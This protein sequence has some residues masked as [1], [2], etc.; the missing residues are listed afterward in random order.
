MDAFLIG[1]ILV[2]IIFIF[3]AYKVFL[4]DF[5]KDTLND[6]QNSNEEEKELS[7]HKSIEGYGQ[8]KTENEKIYIGLGRKGYFQLEE[9]YNL[10][11]ADILF[12]PIHNR[13][14][15]YDFNFIERVH[16]HLV[17]SNTIHVSIN[18]L[19]RQL[20]FN[21]VNELSIRIKAREI[22]SIYMVFQL[23]EAHQN[24][25]SA[26]NA[27]QENIQCLLDKGCLH[28]FEPYEARYDKTAWEQVFFEQPYK[29]IAAEFL[30]FETFKKALEDP[31]FFC[32]E[33]KFYLDEMVLKI[34]F[35]KDYSIKIDAYMGADIESDL[36]CMPECEYEFLSL[37][38]QE[39]LLKIE[40]Y[41]EEQ[42]L[43]RLENEEKA[44]LKGYK[45]DEHYTDP[46]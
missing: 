19:F 7:T 40:Q 8:I 23:V 4:Q 10:E 25:E 5:L 16:S 27:F 44:R 1:L 13:Y 20:Q 31:E 30:D 33:S 29:C 32:I 35:Y 26:F 11:D 9:N 39:R 34:D 37:S 43:I 46:F 6:R 45:I 24:L 38:V 22:V 2:C 36:T 42:K 18:T 15:D 41:K 28:F 12:P 21:H 17:P 3:F 14:V